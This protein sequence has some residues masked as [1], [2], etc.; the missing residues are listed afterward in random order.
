MEPVHIFVSYAHEDKR[1][2]LEDDP[3][4][5][6][7]YLRAALVD[8]KVTIW[9]DPDMPPFAQWRDEIFREIDRADIAL[10]LVSPY[11]IA[12]DFIREEELPRIQKRMERGELVVAPVLVS[13]CEW[14]NVALIEGTQLLPGPQKTL[15]QDTKNDVDWDEARA[16]VA[17]AIRNTVIRV[18]DRRG[19]TSEAE[20]EPT[21]PPNA[22]ATVT[23]TD[24]PQGEDRRP[25]GTAARFAGRLRSMPRSVLLAAAALLVLVGG[26]LVIHSM[27]DG[28]PASDAPPVEVRTEDGSPGQARSASSES[29]RRA[30][31]TSQLPAI[32]TEVGE[33]ITGPDG[34]VY[35]WVPGGSFMMGSNEH[36]ASERPVHRVQLDGF[37]LGKCE[38]TNAQYR[39]F[40]DETGRDFPSQSDQG[41]DHPIVH[42]SWDNANAYCKHYGLSLPTEAQWEYAAAGP[43]SRT[44]PWGDEWD[45]QRLC[46]KENQGAGG[47]TFPVGS[48]PE[49]AS[50]C[51]VLD[52]AGNVSEW[53]ADW[54]QEDYY[55]YTPLENPAGPSTGSFRV[56]RGG[57]WSHIKGE[58]FSK[59]FRCA[60]RAILNPSDYQDNIGFRCVK[61]AL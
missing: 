55:I 38:V 50:W 41:A 21:P 29:A 11:F 25:S 44:Y 35:V 30:V 48:F 53:C 60:N 57:S 10:L 34:G 33:E 37:W 58:V 40:C 2:L 22:G 42:V 23:A 24:L 46:W 39:A 28:P 26:Y 1:W 45:P 31:R 12:S 54:W 47:K 36:L 16:S 5:L 3:H 49:G 61:T 8:L 56:L 51:G 43:E 59:P 14:Q 19:D 15:L 20:P 17:D 6:I 18:R 52:M 4:H 27:S 7:P 9:A 13:R 32:G